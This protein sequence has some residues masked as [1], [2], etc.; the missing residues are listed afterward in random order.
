MQIHE[1]RFPALLAMALTGA[2]VLAGCGQGQAP[3]QAGG[4]AAPQVA[5]FEVQAGE[6]PLVLELPG[7][8]APYLIAEVRPQVGGI[9][10]QRP[11]REGGEV[12]AGELLYQID[13]AT[14]QAAH[15]SAEAG[16]ARAEA[17]LYAARLK[18][19]RFAGLVGIEAVSKQANDDAQAAFKLAEAEV[20]SARAA[21]AKAK[22]DL[23]FTRVT[24]PISGRAGR[25]GVTPGALVTANQ[26]AALVTVQQLDPIYVDLTQSSAELLKL[27]RDLES[28]RVQRKAA[29]ELPVRLLLE[30]GSEY[31]VPGRLAFSEVSVDQATG[32]VTLRAVFPNPNGELL[33]GMYVRARLE[34]GVASGAVLVPHAGVSRD[35]KGNALVMVVNGE[36]TVEARVVRAERSLGDKWV[37]SEGLAPGER[38]IVEG[39]QRVRPGAQVQVA[40]TPATPAAPAAN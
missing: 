17:N 23:D 26:A 7:R 10:K 3:Q 36:N 28:G 18:A 5:V 14:Y 29:E 31:A 16:L 34:Q 19:E 4:A 9:V 20:A 33:P 32:S 22:V 37:V 21:L 13:P 6:V 11:F 30:D 27:R 35:A 2:V 40:G 15:D 12:K 8:T 25:S 24:A 1:R 38:V 39:L